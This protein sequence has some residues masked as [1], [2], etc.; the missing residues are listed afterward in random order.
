MEHPAF[1]N[2]AKSPIERE[3]QEGIPWDNGSAPP[4]GEARK[5]S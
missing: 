1:G 4:R 2:Q 5:S 3:K